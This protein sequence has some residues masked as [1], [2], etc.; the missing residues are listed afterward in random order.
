[1]DIVVE[2]DASGRP[3]VR[4]GWKK[5]L[6]ENPCVSLSH[7]EGFTVAAAGPAGREGLGVDAE[8]LRE[9]AEDFLDGAFADSERRLL[10]GRRDERD[11]WVFRAWCAKEAVGKAL[12]TGV[13]LDPTGLSVTALDSRCGEVHIRLGGAWRQRGAELGR[14]SICASTYR[15]KQHIIAVCSR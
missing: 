1:V 4:G 7:T 9:P 3:V 10:D 14:D 12:G 8:M 15:E 5:D 13:L 2:N 6:P 11:E